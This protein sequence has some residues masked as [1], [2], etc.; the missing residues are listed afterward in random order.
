M[1]IWLASYPKSGNTWLRFLIM[2]LIMKGKGETSL[3]HLSG[4]KQIAIPT[5][6]R[7]I[8]KKRLLS[9]VKASGNNLR[10]VT[11]DLP[12]GMLVCVS[13]V[14]GSGK[15]T[16]VLETLWKTLA[17]DLHR[18]REI[19]SSCEKIEGIHHLDKVV[20]I[21]SGNW[22][23]LALK[24]DGTVIGWLIKD[25]NSLEMSFMIISGRW[26]YFSISQTDRAHGKPVLLKEPV[27][28]SKSCLTKSSWMP[29]CLPMMSTLKLLM[30]R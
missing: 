18:A 10:S 26:E 1:I 22:H 2:S 5:Q 20:D 3:E 30:L 4:I 9:I 15:S 28:H 19:P 7:K 27:E 25:R 6:R 14:S 29:P 12:L 13:G 23:N 16:L 17:R 24:F 11:V 21:D 8:N